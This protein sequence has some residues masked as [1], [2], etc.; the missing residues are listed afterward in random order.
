MEYVVRDIVTGAETS[1]RGKQLHDGLPVTL[2]AGEERMF[3]VTA[4]RPAGS[5]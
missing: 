2:A 1:L 4:V 3:L 5:D